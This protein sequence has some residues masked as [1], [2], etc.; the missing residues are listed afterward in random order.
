LAIGLVLLFLAALPVDAELATIGGEIRLDEAIDTALAKDPR[1][2]VSEAEVEMARGALVAAATYPHNPEIEVF[3]ASRRETGEYEADFGIGVAQEIELPRKRR[4]RGAVADA[5]LQTAQSR[6]GRERLVVASETHMMFVDALE[7]RELLR[8]ARADAGL[9]GRLHDVARRRLQRG[10]A[11]QLELN[12]A[13]AEFGRAEGRVEQAAGAFDAA[14]VALARA[15][16]V[17]PLTPPIPAGSLHIDLPP[18]PGLATLGEKALSG[19][20]DLR[21]LREVEVE[22]AARAE[23]ADLSVWPNLTFGVFAEREAER[24]TIIGGRFSIPVPVFHRSQGEILE[25]RAAIVRA[26]ADR[27]A[28]ELVAEQELS[29]AFVTY[30]SAQRR[31]ER[32]RR[33]VFGNLKSNVALLEKAF[34]AGKTTWSDVLIIGRSLVDAE[35]E[36]VT[37][38]AEA[39][40]NWVTLQLAA[41]LVPLPAASAE[42]EIR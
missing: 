18:P 8:V 10:A 22:S 2:Q 1:L 35:R 42:E 16:G 39:R 24:E 19:R 41:G 27:R 33:R 40:R 7:A 32:L 9:T 6:L 37:A 30:Q 31:A 34:A 36:L 21:A 38:Q 15:M 12:L 29:T 3:G 11:T 17:S 20:K 25:A 13:E 5:R 4:V 26:A 23:L 28:A 14:R